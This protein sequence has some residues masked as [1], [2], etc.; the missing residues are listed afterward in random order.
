MSTTV[1]PTAADAPSPRANGDRAASAEEGLLEPVMKVPEGAGPAVDQASTA[2][3][4]NDRADGSDASSPYGQARFWT[5][6]SNPVPPGARA[7]TLEVDGA[8]LRYAMFKPAPAGGGRRGRGTVLL[9]QGRNEYIEKYFE[10][11]GDLAARGFGVLAFDWRGQGGSTRLLPD[12]QRGYVRSFRDYERD[13]DAIIERVLLPDCRA[14]F[15]I[16][17]HSMGALIALLAAPRHANRIERIVMLGPLLRLTN[18]LVGP[19][20]IAWLAGLLRVFGL[21][22]RYAA[23]GA[24]AREVPEFLTNVLTTDRER[25]ERNGRMLVEHH[26]LGLGGPTVAWVHAASLAMRRATS[27]RHLRTVPIPS[28]MIAAGDDLVVSN[29]AI[30][31]TVAR[32]RN[33]NVLT[34]YGAR[35]EMLQERDRYRE[36]V[37]AA[38]DAFAARPVEDGPV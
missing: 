15:T 11:A 36:Q 12:P 4:R 6:P 24:R 8:T 35:H 13:L 22:K 10:T 19:R 1:T 9:L 18:Q 7:G 31:R 3:P 28:L 27:E 16:V 23:M 38:I 33:A 37:L 32:M 5:I 25:H 21:G 34:V 14:P 2:D 26:H 17:G 20:A 30:E 29:Q